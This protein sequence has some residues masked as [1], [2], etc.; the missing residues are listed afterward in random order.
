MMLPTSE[1]AAAARFRVC[2]MLSAP[3]PP[4][5]IT[6]VRR[7]RDIWQICD[8]SETMRPRLHALQIFGNSKSTISLRHLEFTCWWRSQAFVFATPKEGVLFITLDAQ[9]LFVGDF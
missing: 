8:F 1:L 3:G 4:R 2:H 5:L 6:I 7:Q 9:L